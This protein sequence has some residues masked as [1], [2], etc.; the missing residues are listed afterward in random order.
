MDLLEHELNHG[1]MGASDSSDSNSV[2]YDTY[3]QP[4]FTSD[5]NYVVTYY[6]GWNFGT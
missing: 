5:D 6:Y 3:P 2:M 4:S 1:V